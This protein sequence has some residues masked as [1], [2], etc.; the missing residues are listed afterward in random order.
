MITK[1]ISTSLHLFSPVIS[2]HE[3]T[4]GKHVSSIIH[5][6][7]VRRKIYQ[8]K[9]D[10]DIDT[11]RM[12]LGQAW[13][14]ALI[15]QYKLESPNEYLELPELELDN[16]YGHPDLYHISHRVKE[17]KCTWMSTNHDIESPKLW[18]YLVQLKAYCRML[19]SVYGDLEIV[20]V[21][22]DYKVRKIGYAHWELEFTKTELI[23][24]WRMILSHSQVMESEGFNW[25]T[26][27]YE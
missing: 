22:G 1:L 11:T 3:R 21:I 16:I 5:D 15:Q 19:K 20:F 10:D 13:E 17:I 14:F 9:D 25:E 8:P 23:E 12:R 24:N 2:T 4:K 18:R 6:L 27:E 26:N 7:C